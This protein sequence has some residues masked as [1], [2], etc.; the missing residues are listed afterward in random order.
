[1]QAITSSVPWGLS[2]I[3]LLPKLT[4]V[5]GSLVVVSFL[6]ASLFCGRLCPGTALYLVVRGCAL[7]GWSTA[8]VLALLE[9]AKSVA[10]VARR[11]PDQRGALTW[12]IGALVIAV[13][14]CGIAVIFASTCDLNPHLANCVVP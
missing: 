7:L 6:G 11:E 8:P 14:A 10:L 13:G 5:A 4:V 12:H 3:P 1:M 2:R 9:V